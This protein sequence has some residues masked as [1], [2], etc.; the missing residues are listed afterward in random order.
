MTKESIKNSRNHMGR[1][2]RKLQWRLNHLSEYE[3]DQRD[4]LIRK[5]EMLKICRYE[6]KQ[7]LRQL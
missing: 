1:T 5:I 6:M 4:T 2:M 7:L 3:W